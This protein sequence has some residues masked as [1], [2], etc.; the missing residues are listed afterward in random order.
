MQKKVVAEVKL[1]EKALFSIAFH[2]QSNISMKKY[3]L[4]KLF[5]EKKSL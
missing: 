2:W 4:L 3:G 1:P 5:K